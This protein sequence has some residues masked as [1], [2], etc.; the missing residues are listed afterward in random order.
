M[1]DLRSGGVKL[2]GVGFLGGLPRWKE[3]SLMEAGSGEGG[4]AQCH[5]GKPRVR[6]TLATR[7]SN[8]KHD[9]LRLRGGQVRGRRRGIRVTCL[10]E[11]VVDGGRGWGKRTTTLS[12]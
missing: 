9:Q 11:G 6:E 8:Y 3:S 12:P 5:R 10:A 2:R 7:R 4:G 1:L